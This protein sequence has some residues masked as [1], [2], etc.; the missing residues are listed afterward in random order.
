MKILYLST[1]N[2]GRSI[3]A[4]SIT[5]KYAHMGI[6]AASG[7]SKPGDDIHVVAH[8]VLKDNHFS[9]V[10]LVRKSWNTFDTWGADIVIT[11]CNKVLKE[12]CPTYVGKSVHVHWGMDDPSTKFGNMEDNFNKVFSVLNVRIE[13]MLSIDITKLEKEDLRAHLKKAI[14]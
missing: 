9:S 5:R 14:L 12:K 7:G 6:K 8:R 3:I 2:M 11:L 1:N 13:K 10:S 4:E